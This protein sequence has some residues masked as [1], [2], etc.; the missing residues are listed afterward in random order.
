M[1]IPIEFLDYFGLSKDFYKGKKI[2]DIGCGPRGSLEWADMTLERV[3]LDPPGR[4]IL[5]D[6][7]QAKNN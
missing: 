5:K 4:K 1:V 3:G 7:Y 6:N 2:L